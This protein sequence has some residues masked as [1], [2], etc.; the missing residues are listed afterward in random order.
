MGKGSRSFGLRRREPVFIRRYSAHILI[1]RR[2]RKEKA[3]GVTVHGGA[4][5]AYQGRSRCG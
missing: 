1:C 4:E 5:R 3:H 2:L